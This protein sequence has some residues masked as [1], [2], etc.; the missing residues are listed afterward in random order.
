MTV[1]VFFNVKCSFPRPAGILSKRL[2]GPPI[3]TPYLNQDTNKIQTGKLRPWN[4]SKSEFLQTFGV[5]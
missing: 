4:C 5:F 2:A 3:V 1:L